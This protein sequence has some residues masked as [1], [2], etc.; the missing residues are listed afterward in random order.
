VTEN[1]D[2]SWTAADEALIR[3]AWTGEGLVVL[4]P[5]DLARMVELAG[6]RKAEFTAIVQTMTR[7][8]AEYV[9]RI[10]CHDHFTWR[11]VASACYVEWSGHWHPPSNQLMGMAICEK[12][13][14]FF[15][16]DYKDDPWN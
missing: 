7:D 16:E 8:Q 6:R 11:A 5:D 9:R 2:P 4:R 15:G 12:A 10:R 3:S 1:T 13:A 14:S